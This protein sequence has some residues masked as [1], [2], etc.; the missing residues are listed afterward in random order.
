MEKVTTSW[1]TVTKMLEV[2]WSVESWLFHGV[3]KVEVLVPGGEEGDTGEV[4]FG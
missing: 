2:V 4:P 1:I 3:F